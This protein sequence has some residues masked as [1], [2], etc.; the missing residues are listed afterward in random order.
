M[1]TPAIGQAPNH[2]EGNTTMQ[3]KTIWIVGGALT[4]GALAAAVA[5]GVGAGTA[6][7]GGADLDTVA[8]QA[9]ALRSAVAGARPAS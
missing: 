5:V 8:E 9:A 6:G 7:A 3:R 1:G 2:H 4:S